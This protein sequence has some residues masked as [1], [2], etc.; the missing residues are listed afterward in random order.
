MIIIINI[1]IL[2]T[3]FTNNGINQNVSVL[4]QLSN[5]LEKPM[6][7]VYVKL[8][9]NSKIFNVKFWF[10]NIVLKINRSNHRCNTLWSILI[11]LVVLSD[12]CSAIFPES[13]H[14]RVSRLRITE[15]LG[16]MQSPCSYDQLAVTDILPTEA[17]GYGLKES[18][19]AREMQQHF[20]GS[21]PGRKNGQKSKPNAL[22]PQA[23][24]C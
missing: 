1:T 8:N 7:A 17:W 12:T 18:L 11:V 3:K 14:F 24:S 21:F 15:T 9:Y 4:N 2:C 10:W 20:W 5:M 16:R 13:N 6:S 23:I 22:K 19:E